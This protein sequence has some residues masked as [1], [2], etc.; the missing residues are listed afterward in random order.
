MM[1]RLCLAYNLPNDFKGSKKQNKTNKK[2]TICHYFR[3]IIHSY[4]PEY[5][6]AMLSV[7]VYL[8]NNTLFP[9]TRPV[10]FVVNEF[11]FTCL[12]VC[13]IL[14]SIK[15]KNKPNVPLLYIW[16]QCFTISSSML[17]PNVTHRHLY[18]ER[19]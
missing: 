17:T 2:I 11:P 4:F 13:I 9:K 1:N 12:P 5:I 10:V 14:L 8:W 3:F 7:Y 6:S 16:L 15:Q 18:L 19:I